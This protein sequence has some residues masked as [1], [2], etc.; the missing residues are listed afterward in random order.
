MYRYETMDVVPR[1]RPASILPI[2][3]ASAETPYDLRSNYRTWSIKAKILPWLFGNADGV[4]FFLGFEYGIT[5]NQSIGIDGFAYFEGASNDMVLDT[6][7]NT[8]Q[9][10]DNWNSTEKAI[11]LD[12]RYYFDSQRLRRRY[13]IAPYLLAYVRDGKI[14]R[15]YDPLYPLS[16]YW[17]DHERHYSAGLQLGTSLKGS[18][19]WNLDVNCGLFVK[20]KVVSM[21]YLNRGV[22]STIDSRP[23]ELGFRLSVNLFWWWKIPNSPSSAPLPH[24]NRKVY[25]RPASSGYLSP[26]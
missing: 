25:K 22:V 26:D 19:F 12:Y 16:A 10:G 11:F 18:R 9:F 3:S 1:I 8:H 14:D 2:D 21:E 23:L 20:E 17:Q 24:P 13:G 6:A 15:S 4:S 7:G 5:K